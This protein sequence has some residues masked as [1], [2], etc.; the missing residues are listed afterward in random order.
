MCETAARVQC[1]NVVQREEREEKEEKEKR[2]GFI[3]KDCARKWSQ[4]DYSVSRWMRARC[5]K[6]PICGYLI[7]VNCQ[8]T[9]CSR[10]SNFFDTKEIYTMME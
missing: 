8:I 5:R 6:D 1:K 7:S 3:R 4:V 9:L 10:F 2:N